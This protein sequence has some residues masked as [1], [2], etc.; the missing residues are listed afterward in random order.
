MNV[1]SIK[2]IKIEDDTLLV[3]EVD[4][5]HM[6]LHTIPPS[7]IIGNIKQIIDTFR[8]ETGKSINCILV[9][10]GFKINDLN[11]R[12]LNNIFLVKKSK[13]TEVLEDCVSISKIACNNCESKRKDT[14]EM[15]IC[16]KYQG[17][18]K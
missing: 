3:I 9:Q 11:E 4:Q 16:N 1:E 14:C 5:R 17:D 2:Q 8:K 7:D 6:F 12:E 15:C 18:E 13:Y 10:K